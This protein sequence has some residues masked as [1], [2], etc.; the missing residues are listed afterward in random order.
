MVVVGEARSGMEALAL[1]RQLEP[2]VLVLDLAMPGL[3]G[4][5]V[6]RRLQASGSRT[7]I[8]VLTMHASE[9]YVREALRQGATGY[10]LKDSGIYELAAAVKAAAAGQRFLSEPLRVI[11]LEDEL[12]EDHA[13][14]GYETLTPREREIF[15]LTVEGS[16]AAEVAALLSVSPRTV[17]V[18]RYNLMQKLGVHSQAELVMYALRRGLLPVE[19]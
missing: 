7:R 18:H 19:L 6:M 14:A 13:S 1:T 11:P 15:Q 5:E 4:M 12:W 8:V 17:E 10:V 16:S 9:A 2:D 3:S